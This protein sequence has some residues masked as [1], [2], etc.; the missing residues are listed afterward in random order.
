MKH[1]DNNS[2]DKR[3]ELSSPIF[4]HLLHQAFR[5][6]G[7]AL[8]DSRS[9]Y[10]DPTEGK[11]IHSGE[12]GSRREIAVRSLIRLLLPE[13][14]GIA[15]GFIINH[16]GDISPQV[17]VVIYRKS[18]TPILVTDEKQRFFP[19]ECVVAVGEVKSAISGRTELIQH[20]KKLARVSS[21]RK[22]GRFETPS[23]ETISVDP[24]NNCRHSILTFLI[25]ASF[26]GIKK[27]HESMFSELSPNERPNLVYS[28][29]DGMLRYER[30]DT[31]EPIG[32]PYVRTT[33]QTLKFMKT[34]PKE[35]GRLVQLH[36]AVLFSQ[37]IN[38]ATALQ[39][40]FAHYING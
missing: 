26:G 8:D 7:N 15:D 12:Y 28:F 34:G 37:L 35:E 4:K 14:Y 11:L 31:G 39:P 32:Y 6:L 33:S 2:K 24:L 16:C 18:G 9:L 17:D 30:P 10:W 27:F 25:C 38:L 21:L 40:D 20:L 22:A 29:A 19:Q 1:R 13:T 3:I 23:A 36:F 5:D